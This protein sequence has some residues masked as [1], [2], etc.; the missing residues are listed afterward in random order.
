MLFDQKQKQHAQTENQYNQIEGKTQINHQTC[1]DQIQNTLYQCMEAV[2]QREVNK[3]D[4][5]HIEYRTR[6][7][8]KYHTEP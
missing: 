4:G 5:S 8:T 7:P 2:Q 3:Q 6:T 1:Q